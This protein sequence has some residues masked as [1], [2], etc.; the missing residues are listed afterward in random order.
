VR[1]VMPRCYIFEAQ[2]VADQKHQ[3]SQALAS[4]V[5]GTASN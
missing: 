2:T 4:V 5:S 1:A 3:A